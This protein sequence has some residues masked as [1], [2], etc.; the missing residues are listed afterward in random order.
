MV[1]FGKDFW[2]AGAIAAFI[3]SG[4]VSIVTFFETSSH[5]TEARAAIV[6]KVKVNEAATTQLLNVMCATAIDLKWPTA[7]KVCEK[8]SFQP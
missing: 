4:T 3:A 2:K 5:A 8:N 6:K 7:K 1:K